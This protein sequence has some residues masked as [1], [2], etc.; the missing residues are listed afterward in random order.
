MSTMMMTMEFFC[1]NIKASILSSGAWFSRKKL[2]HEKKS[3]GQRRK[4]SI[5][6]QEK[7]NSEIHC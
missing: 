2:F 7:K 4:K 6:K 5:V 3:F 1:L